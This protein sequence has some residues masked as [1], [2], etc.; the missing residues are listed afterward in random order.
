MKILVTGGCGYIGSHTCCELLDSGHEVVIIDNL[1]N[2][3]K[4][5]IDK[6][7]LICNKNTVFYE[8]ELSDKV[9]LQTIFKKEKIDAVIH[10]AGSKSVGESVKNPLK[11]YDNNLT[12]S[13]ILLEVMK[14]FNCKK[15][16][17]SSSA[18]VYGIPGKLPI[19]ENFSLLP[20]TPYGSTKLTIEN[21]LKDLY[22]SDNNW[23]I[24]ILRYFN[25]IGAHE[26]GLLGEEPT[27]TPN[28]LMPYIV[29]VATKQLECLSIYGNDYDTIDGTAVRDYIH[30]IDLSLAHI[31]ALEKIN[32]DKGMYIYNIG[33]GKG[34]SVLEI[35]NKFSQ[36]NNI[37]VKYEIVGR[38]PGD[39]ASYCADITKAKE[40]LGFVATKTLE[41][42]CKD[43][44]NFV[45]KNKNK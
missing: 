6:I 29:K 44:Y 9:L 25:P 4:D 31:K 18:A 10:L 13:I 19:K 14:E 20:I 39:I 40:E 37:E 35:V 41:D 34:Y 17:F 30:V 33:T 8:G 43:S 32:E 22:N 1:S 38:R 11:Y 3:K 23:N 36:V 12:S 28:N 27:G 16:V 45:V 42:M 21:I 7:K 15:I 24:V 2:S 26:S 5:V